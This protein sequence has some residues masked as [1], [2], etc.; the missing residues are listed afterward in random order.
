M[1]FNCSKTVTIH[2]F[3]KGST[4]YLLLHC[5][6]ANFFCTFCLIKDGFKEIYIYLLGFFCLKLYDIDQAI[7]FILLVFSYELVDILSPWY[8]V[9][10]LLKAYF[11]LCC[12]HPCLLVFWWIVLSLAILSLFL[13]FWGWRTA[14]KVLWIYF[15]NT[16]C[17]YES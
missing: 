17:D 6:M 11:D 3:I 14:I 9:S 8:I 5:F 4:L 1:I 13:T 12:S 10:S 16:C 7:V 2:D 15:F